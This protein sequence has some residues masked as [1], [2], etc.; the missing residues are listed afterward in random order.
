M[1][2]VLVLLPALVSPMLTQKCLVL[3]SV[4][5]FFWMIDKD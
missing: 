2:N 5:L 3:E 1:Q 4:V